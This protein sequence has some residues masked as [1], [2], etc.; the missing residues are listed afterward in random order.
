MNPAFEILD[1]NEPVPPVVYVDDVL[2][3]VGGSQVRASTA[4]G[5]L[6]VQLLGEY[7]ADVRVRVEGTPMQVPAL[8]ALGGAAL[9]AALLAASARRIR[10]S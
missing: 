10:K 1:W 6:I 7:G 2:Q 9:A 3:L 5:S 4:S 8:P